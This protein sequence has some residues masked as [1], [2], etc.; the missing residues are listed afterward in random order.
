MLK[1]PTFAEVT[2]Q[3]LREIRRARSLSLRHASARSS[4]RFKPSSLASYE[5]GKRQI[6]LE[7]L[8]ELAE[9]Y[10]VTPERIVAAIAFHLERAH[11][12]ADVVRVEGE[13]PLRVLDPWSPGTPI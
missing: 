4:G 9:V 10:G 1:E 6:S 3:V 2:G 8:F 5:R 11:V 13:D 7:R 12:P